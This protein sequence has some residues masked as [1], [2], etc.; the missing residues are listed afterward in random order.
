MA[1]FAHAQ[2]DVMGSKQDPPATPI[3]RH[4]IVLKTL[5]Y[6]KMYLRIEELR[7]F[8]FPK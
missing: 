1:K 2:A 3:V 5:K 6:E 4:I 8:I 7:C